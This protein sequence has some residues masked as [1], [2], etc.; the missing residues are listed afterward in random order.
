MTDFKLP[1]VNSNK[2]NKWSPADQIIKMVHFEI[3]NYIT[4]PSL[5]G[6]RSIRQKKIV[7]NIPGGQV[8]SF[9]P[10]LTFQIEKNAFY[11]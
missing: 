5:R 8:G 9:L 10:F 4:H 1:M 11:S 3:A 2:I 7:P 6:F